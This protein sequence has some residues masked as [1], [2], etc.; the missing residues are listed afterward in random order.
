[1]K[2]YHVDFAVVGSLLTIVFLLVVN[3]ITSSDHLW[4]IYPAL[5]LLFWPIRLYCLKKGKQQYFSIFSSLL[6][7]VYLGI[8]NYINTP[9]YPWFLYAVYPIIWWPILVLLGKRAKSTIVALIGSI[10][11]ILYYLC[12]NILLAPGHPWFIYPAFVVLWWPLSIYHAR[13]KSYYAF[14]I[15]GTIL[16]SAFF[17]TVN[18]ITSPQEIWAIYP[19][20]GVLW[21]PLSVYYFVYKRKS[22]A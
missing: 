3:L 9:A 22:E 11:I 2:K 7:I 4:F 13:K 20:F 1:M 5:I 17:I 8:V 14:S 6:I 18:L 12:L 21:W 16:I 19:I 10:S 15:N